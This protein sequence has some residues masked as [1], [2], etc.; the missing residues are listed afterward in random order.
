M[1]NLR[2]FSLGNCPVCS[3]S[4]AVLLIAEKLSGRLLF[5]CPLCGVAWKKPPIPDQLDEIRSLKEL[6]PEGIS[7]PTD[8]Q[9]FG[10][11]FDVAV[12]SMELWL[13]RLQDELS[14]EGM[15]LIALLPEP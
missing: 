4:G 3:D 13:P 7:L 8:G 6:A 1:M 2:L 5:H 10:S 9:V 11:G 12:S 15:P 14:R